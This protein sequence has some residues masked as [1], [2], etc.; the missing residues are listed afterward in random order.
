MGRCQVRLFTEGEAFLKCC[1][2]MSG[3]RQIVFCISS[4]CMWWEWVEWK[5]ESGMTYGQN[6]SGEKA[7]LY[8]GKCG[9][10]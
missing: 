4:E 9:K 7:N 1:P 8:R 6:P 10:V 2:M 3:F 5:G